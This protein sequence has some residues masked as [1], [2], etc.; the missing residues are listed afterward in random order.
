LTLSNGQIRLEIGYH[1]Q[2]MSEERIQREAAKAV[3]D[4]NCG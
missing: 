4:W 3:R 2:K 1:I